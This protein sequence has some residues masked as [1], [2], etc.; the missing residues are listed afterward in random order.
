MK[1]ND[2]GL[3]PCKLTSPFVFTE[4][5]LASNPRVGEISFGNI[6]TIKMT[7]LI[8]HMFPDE[9]HLFLFF[10]ITFHYIDYCMHRIS[11]FNRV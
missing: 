6:V 3:D 11:N 9:L 5:A 10:I 2:A 7:A 1:I 8:V 4:A